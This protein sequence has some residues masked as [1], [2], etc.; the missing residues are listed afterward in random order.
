MPN[1]NKNRTKS[2]ERSTTSRKDYSS[3]H[4]GKKSSGYDNRNRTNVG[5]RASAEK[6]VDEMES[7]KANHPQWWMKYPQLSK[8]S[9]NFVFNTIAGT[10]FENLNVG[11]PDTPNN[12]QWPIVGSSMRFM[13]VIGKSKKATDAYNYQMRALWLDMHRKY[14]GIGTYQSADLGMVMFAIVGVMSDL[15]R[16]ERMYGMA[17]V[18]NAR[19][20]SY[21]DAILKAMNLDPST[22]NGNRVADFRYQL[23]RLILKAQTLCLPKGISLLDCY[24]G[25]LSQVF[26]DSENVRAQWFLYEDPMHYQYDHT[27]LTQGGCIR[28]Y[29]RTMTGGEDNNLQTFAD[30]I[31][32]LESD[33]DVLLRDDDAARM[34]SDLLA[35]YGD[36]GITKL[37]PVPEDYRIEPVHEESRVLEL[38]NTTITSALVGTDI[39]NDILSQLDPLDLGQTYTIYQMNNVIRQSIAPFATMS[40][41]SRTWATDPDDA[42]TQLA[43]SS[44]SGA[45]QVYYGTPMANTWKDDPSDEEK[46]DL[47]IQMAGKM[48]ISFEYEGDTWYAPSFDSY[49]PYIC[50]GLALWSNKNGGEVLGY[51]SDDVYRLTTLAKAESYAQ[52]VACLSALD[53]H[54]RIFVRGSNASYIGMVWDIDNY[55]TVPRQALKR[56]HEAAILSATKFDVS[57]IEA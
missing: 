17:S 44:T 57:I 32:D 18:F 50:W 30:V 4:R 54:P 9:L 15:A 27:F 41:A 19:N 7:Y 43:V 34:C 38:M 29:P 8:D 35:C 49:G 33:I 39:P 3:T 26:K 36:A 28:Y 55:T 21:P 53:W 25:L 23:N 48:V 11:L 51:V 31:T 37:L 10:E 12:I 46:V 24:V 52:M 14:R 1:A 47:L 5:S 13:R 6:F 40:M 22:I 56:V 20:R 45:D 2:G 16:A 42:N